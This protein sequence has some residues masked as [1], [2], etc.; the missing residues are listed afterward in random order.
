MYRI[1]EV[2]L[3]SITVNSA[4]TAGGNDDKTVVTGRAKNSCL[5]VFNLLDVANNRLIED[6]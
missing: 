4:G 2:A 6:Q 3:Y 1:V 5:V